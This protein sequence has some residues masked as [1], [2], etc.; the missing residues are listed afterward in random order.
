MF[1]GVI[2]VET[3]C[4]ERLNFPMSGS[5]NQ[6]L[7]Q[8]HKYTMLGLDQATRWKVFLEVV[9]GPPVSQ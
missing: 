2:R 5:D 4:G 1:G 8:I 6:T 7:P 9:S 3:I